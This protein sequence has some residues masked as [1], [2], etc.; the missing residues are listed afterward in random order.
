MVARL[1]VLLTAIVLSAAG[2]TGA[3]TSRTLTFDQVSVG[4]LPPGF[5]TEAHRQKDPGLWSVV[6]VGTNPALHHS[7]APGADGWSLAL[8]DAP[9]QPNLRVTARA[10]L[11]GGSHAGGL[12]W[13]YQDPRNF[14][15]VILDLDDGDIELFRVADGNRIRLDDRDGLD[16]DDQAWHTLRVSY[17]AG[18]TTVSIGGIRVLDRNE[19]RPP[20]SGG[21]VGI[22]AH[23]GTDAAFDDLRIEAPAG[24]QD[25]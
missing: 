21:R 8:V 24:R 15:A 12:V 17:E 18:K 19:R 22:V 23:G 9:A 7:A 25:R 2:A 4:T 13:H 16:L 20:P 3:Q 1:L 10:R 6:R 14:M 11:S 5:T